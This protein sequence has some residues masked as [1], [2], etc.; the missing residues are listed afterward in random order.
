MPAFL[1][2]HVG[3]VDVLNAFRHHRGGHQYKGEPYRWSMAV[4]NAFRHHRGGHAGLPRTHPRGQECSTPFGITEVGI[5]VFHLKYPAILDVLNAFRHHRGGHSSRSDHRERDHSPTCSTPFGIT[6][7][8]IVLLVVMR[9]DAY[10]AQRLSASQRWALS[11]ALC[12]ASFLPACSTP[13][14]ITE[15]GI[16]YDR[17]ELSG[18]DPVLNAFRH[19]RGGHNRDVAGS[20]PAPR[21]SCSTPFGITEV[22]I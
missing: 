6:E 2:V 9:M 1:T 3:I 5:C 18:L 20:T 11:A 12:R 17:R 16:F 7:V 13:F 10:C 8:G 15:V 21:Q 14:G 19:H 22:G 4:L